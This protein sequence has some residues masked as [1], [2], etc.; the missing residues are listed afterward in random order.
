MSTPISVPTKSSLKTAMK[1]MGKG[2]L[3]GGLL[4]LLISILGPVGAL[5]APIITGS[6]M[7]GET[8]KIV[9]TVAGI[10]AGVAIVGK[11]GGGGGSNS[12]STGGI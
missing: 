5:L 9:T 8:G 10:L 3:G 6:F 4:A 7:K 1:D 11:F 12:G 2:F